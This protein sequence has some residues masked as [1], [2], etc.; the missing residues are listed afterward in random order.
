MSQKGKYISLG[1]EGTLPR[2]ILYLDF[3]EVEDPFLELYVE[4]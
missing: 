4:L 1:F 2:I 3:L